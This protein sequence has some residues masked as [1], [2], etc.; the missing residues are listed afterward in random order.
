M[1]CEVLVLDRLGQFSTEWKSTAIRGTKT[2]SV[3]GN[4][5]PNIQACPNVT[6]A[7]IELLKKPRMISDACFKEVERYVVVMYQHTSELSLC[8]EAIIHM[9]TCGRSMEK[10]P[11]TTDALFHHVKRCVLQ[12][13]Y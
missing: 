1:L 9:F 7:F 10:I 2:V 4:G 6:G 3:P 12:A 13:G 8:N 5:E 11:T